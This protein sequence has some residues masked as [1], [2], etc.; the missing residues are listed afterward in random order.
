[1]YNYILIMAKIKII[2]RKFVVKN[3]KIID[4]KFTY[5]NIHQF[6]G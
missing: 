4:R 3:R 1:M 5:Y 6:L 2:E